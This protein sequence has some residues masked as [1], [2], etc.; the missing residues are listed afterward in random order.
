MNSPSTSSNAANAAVRF[1][2]ERMAN[3]QTVSAGWSCTVRT[4]KD[5]E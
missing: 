3:Q 4:N 2:E 1:Q 5:A